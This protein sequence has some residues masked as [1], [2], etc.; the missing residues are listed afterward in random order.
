MVLNLARHDVLALYASPKLLE[1]FAR[2]LRGKKFRLSDEQIEILLDDLMSFTYPGHE[3]AVSM[4][5][6]RDSKD[7]FLCSLAAGSAADYLVTGDQDLL[8]LRNIKKTRVVTPRI[9]L[10]TKFPELME[11]FERDR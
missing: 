5:R 1:E 8:V 3:A 2:T 6:L 4:P 10:E 9:F 7:Y 11:V